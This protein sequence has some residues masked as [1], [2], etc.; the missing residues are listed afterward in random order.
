[1]ERVEQIGSRVLDHLM[2]NIGI[3]QT[4]MFCT[5]SHNGEKLGAAF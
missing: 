1:M 5:F 3:N 4:A 2:A